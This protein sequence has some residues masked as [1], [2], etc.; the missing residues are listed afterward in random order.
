MKS[1]LFLLV[2]AIAVIT[3]LSCKKTLSKLFGGLDV[4]LPD[5]M[6][7]VPQVPFVPSQEISLG[8]FT[9]HQNIDSTIKANT[10]GFF[11]IGNISSVKVKSVTVSFTNS[12]ATNNISNFESARVTLTSPSNSNPATLAALSFPDEA[13]STY[14]STNVSGDELIPYLSGNEIY[15]TVYGKMRKTTSH[16]LN[17]VVSIK[18]HAQ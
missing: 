13:L 16:S 15:Y 1:K 9:M 4:T 10:G 8:T 18:V 7:V 17:M 14:T 3:A 2:M 12:D 11:G 5:I 6:L